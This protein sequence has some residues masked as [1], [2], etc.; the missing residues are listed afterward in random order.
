MTFPICVKARKVNLAHGVCMHLHDSFRKNREIC[1]TKPIRLE[2]E[3]NNV[4]F[5]GQFYMHEYV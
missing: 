2:T 4:Y 1:V 3:N 5:R